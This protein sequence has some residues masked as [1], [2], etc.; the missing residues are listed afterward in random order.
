MKKEWFFNLLILLLVSIPAFVAPVLFGARFYLYILAV[1]VPCFLGGAIFFCKSWFSTENVI[2]PAGFSFGLSILYAAWLCSFAPVEYHNWVHVLGLAGLLVS[3]LVWVALCRKWSVAKVVFGSLLVLLTALCWYGVWRLQNGNIGFYHDQH[4]VLLAGQNPFY[5][6]SRLLGTYY[7]PNSFSGL[8]ISGICLSLGMLF[9]KES[10]LILKL[11]SLQYLLVAFPTVYLCGSRSGWVEIAIVLFVMFSLILWKRSRVWGSI[12][13]LL[14]SGGFLGCCYLAWKYVP[15]I[16]N[17]IAGGSAGRLTLWPKAIEMVENFPLF[18][19]GVGMFKHAYPSY[20]AYGTEIQTAFHPFNEYLFVAV[21]KGLVGLGL[22]LFGG[23]VLLVRWWINYSRSKS[24]SVSVLSAMTI[25]L[26]L[27]ALAHAMFDYNFL[28]YGNCAVIVLI[29]G[30]SAGLAFPEKERKSTVS[31]SRLKSAFSV[32]ITIM[33][34]AA[35]TI[36]FMNQ[37]NFALAN[38]QLYLAK[39]SSAALELFNKAERWND[40]YFL[41]YYERAI[42]NR[43][44]IGTVDDYESKK[45]FHGLALQDYARC[46]ELNPGYNFGVYG[47]SEMYRQIR[48]YDMQLAFLREAISKDPQRS[49]YWQLYFGRLNSLGRISEIRDASKLV[50]QAGSLTQNQLRAILNK[51]KIKD[52]NV[53]EIAAEIKANPEQVSRRIFVNDSEALEPM[54]TFERDENGAIINPKHKLLSWGL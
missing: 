49:L 15:F 6:G 13:S 43:R 38:R 35:S 25:A 46:Y 17:R 19:W 51:L 33:L 45:E 40:D 9:I 21:E 26:L 23:L 20:K 54:F 36:L 32:A 41:M 31:I 30:I 5:K 22:A 16:Q 4:E 18:G 7:S 29:I 12:L 42:A 34:L 24:W 3:Y 47:L 1:L 14:F 50:L 10:G 27:G 44:M 37:L 8:V 2:V 39:D 28:M 11:L 48:N 52:V 53:T